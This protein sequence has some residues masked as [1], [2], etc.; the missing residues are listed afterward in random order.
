MLF[1]G[2]RLGALGSDD[3]LLNEVEIPIVSLFFC[4]RGAGVRIPCCTILYSL[5]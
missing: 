5:G 2:F 4:H 1:S 3:R